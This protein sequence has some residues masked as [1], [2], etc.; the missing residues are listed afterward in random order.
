[1]L[2]FSANQSANL[3]L[4]SDDTDLDTALSTGCYSEVKAAEE[5]VAKLINER[6]VSNTLDITAVTV[7]L[8]NEICRRNNVQVL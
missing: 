3:W 1:M 6:F 4:P 5:A 7:L 8:F 2:A